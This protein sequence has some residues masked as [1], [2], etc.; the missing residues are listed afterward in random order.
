[1][2]YCIPQVINGF[3]GQWKVGYVQILLGISLLLLLLFEDIFNDCNKEWKYIAWPTYVL[4]YT[5]SD[6]I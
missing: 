5:Q 2:F 4:K 1:M 6:R 3:N